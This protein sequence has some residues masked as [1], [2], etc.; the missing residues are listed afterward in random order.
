MGAVLRRL[1]AL[2][3]RR[4]MDRDLDDELAFHLAMRQEE[5]AVRGVAPTDADLTVRRHFGNVLR[6][7]EQARDAWVFAWVEGALQD[8]RFALRALRRSP[9]FAAVAISVLAVGIGG[10]VAIFSIVN[11][12]LLRPLPF[13]DSDRVVYIQG[14]RPPR[15]TS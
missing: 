1:I 2:F 15:P 10:T 5:H 12:V 7:K 13:K 3:R 8:V 4:R 6:V 9:G 14:S 11:A